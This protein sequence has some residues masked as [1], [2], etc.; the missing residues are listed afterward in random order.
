MCWIE[1]VDS[2]IF[3]KFS[4]KK[5]EGNIGEAVEQKENICDEVETV[6]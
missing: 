1:K 6:K 4:C 3:K 2:N 5:Y